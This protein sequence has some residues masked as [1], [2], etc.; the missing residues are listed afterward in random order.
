MDN[1]VEVQVG[2]EGCEGS[3]YEVIHDPGIPG[4]ARARDV[5]VR[6]LG[7]RGTGHRWA[8][9][10]GRPLC[11][12]CEDREADPTVAVFCGGLCCRA[13]AEDIDAALDRAPSA[14]P[15]PLPHEFEWTESD[16]LVAG[17]GR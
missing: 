13:C 1:S 2:C 11:A 10:V 4:F 3:G 17:G 15:S 16:A 5:R 7:C 6:C 9:P 12:L 14:E 8:K